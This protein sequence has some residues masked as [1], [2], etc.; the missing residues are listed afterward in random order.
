MFDELYETDDEA[1]AR[2]A[3]ILD[4]YFFKEPGHESGLGLIYKCR[5]FKEGCLA[6]LR[7]MK[8]G[9]LFRILGDLNHNYQNHTKEKPSIHLPGNENDE[10]EGDMITYLYKNI[11]YDLF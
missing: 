7:L 4:D 5:Y 8:D 1:K 6:N 11:S 9:V 2:S 3:F 10:R